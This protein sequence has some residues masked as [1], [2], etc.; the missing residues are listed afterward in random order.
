MPTHPE[1]PRAM[2]RPP[3]KNVAIQRVSSLYTPSDH[4]QQLGLFSITEVERDGIAMGVLS[5]GTPYLSLRGLAR[6]CGVDHTSLLPLTTNWKEEKL[7]P[8]GR[9]I[10]A[11][12]EAQKFNGSDLYLLTNGAN[13]E[14]HAYTDAVCMAVLEYYAFEATQANSETA[15]K[16]FRLLARS[17]FRAFI[18]QG[19]GYDPDKHVPEAWRTFA[20]RVMLN[21]QVPI[22]YFSIFREIADF[23]VHMIK[24]GGQLDSHTVLD[25]SVGIMWSNHWNKANFEDRYGSRIKHPHTFP[26]WFPQAAA[27]PVGAWIYPIQSLGDFKLWL[28]EN[29]ANTSFPKYIASKV[30]QGVF[31]PARA[32]ALISAVQR[33]ALPSHP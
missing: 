9:K 26:D 22:G 28:Y 16:N 15:L 1:I 8:R 23:N 21:D 12:L 6:M 33:P 11:L 24:A 25:G 32:N 18:Y 17:S 19:C 3:A 13:G 20:E 4:Q 14:T 31:L 29:Y 7:K 27:N 30:K 2:P 10:Q 5:D